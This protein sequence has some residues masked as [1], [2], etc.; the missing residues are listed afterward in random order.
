MF[1]A[2]SR[3]YKAL[4]SREKIAVYGDFDVDGITATVILVEGLSWL[5][6]TAVPYLPD[7]YNEGHGLNLGA[8]EKLRDQGI[9]LIIT[10][11][12]GISDCEEVKRAREMG[13]DM[14]I[15]DHHVPSEVLPQAVAVIN[16]KRE[17][18]RYPF[19]DL[20][21]VGVAFKLLQAL[22]HKH[23]REGSL[24]EL[25]DLVAL[26]TV[27][28]MVPLVG[29]NRYLVKEGIK[30]LNNTR[31]I[32]LQEMINL[33]GLK[34]GGIDTEH[35]SWVLGPR[36]NAA[37]R[38][39][40]AS[41]SYELLIAQSSE[42]ARHLARELEQK[43]AERQRLTDEVL[44]K[45]KERLADRTHLPLLI[46]G[47]EDYPLGVIGLI[48]G[49]LVEE[50]H[51]PAIVLSLGPERCR[52]SCRSIPEFNIA[53]ALEKSRELL[54]TFGGHP[55]AAGFTLA[56]QNLAELEGR[57]MRLAIDQLGHLDLHP[58]LG[59]DAEVPLSIFDSDTLNMIQKFA[60]FGRGNPVPT[61][62]TRGVEVVEHR[63]LGNQGKH[64]ELKIKQ[65]NAIWRAVAFNLG[66]PQEVV[67]SY[68]YAVYNIEKTW[69]NGEEVLRLNLLDFAPS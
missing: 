12:C 29:E 57:I 59:I 52:G 27:T 16:P 17:D 65:G 19:L 45:V 50:F 63:N 34:P 31:R 20:A 37:S 36:I 9:N 42:E 32:G 6:A 46:E 25:L 43:N 35:I 67:P 40:S 48:A 58:E 62:L 5:G 38:I 1:P 69:W 47:H 61:F 4:L 3:I 44:K 14:I 53:A 55:L 24:G 33:A 8:I 68:V 7:R 13:I 26:G 66:E 51:K 21:G 60:P 56:R 23:S 18:S 39:N 10:V 22:L 30:V 15:S 41:T 64:L 54:I 2:V 11:D 49:R 28:D